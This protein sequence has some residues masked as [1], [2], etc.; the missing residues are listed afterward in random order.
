M[1][2]KNIAYILFKEGVSGQDIARIMKRSEQTISRWKK[3]G[4]WDVKATEDLMAMQTIHEDI[5]DLVRY[6]LFQLRK[7]KDK[8]TEAETE[9]GEPKLISKG[10]IDGVRD[11]YNMIKAKET[12]WTTLVRIIRKINK[13]LKVNYPLLA[14]DVA[15]ALNDF[16]NEERGS[17][18]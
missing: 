11:L 18:S 5:R 2:D 13:F 3:E 17:M 10:D 12:A 6:Q 4:A 1:D 9:S 16:L 14:R 15:P 7:L 8:Y